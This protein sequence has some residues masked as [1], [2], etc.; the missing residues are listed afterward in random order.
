M[1]ELDFNLSDEKI[2]ELWCM[3]ANARKGQ[4]QAARDENQMMFVYFSGALGAYVDVLGL[5]A[6]EDLEPDGSETNKP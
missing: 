2:T 3:F 1:T 5:A 4:K 6:P